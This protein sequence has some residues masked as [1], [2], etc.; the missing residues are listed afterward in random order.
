MPAIPPDFVHT[1]ETE[2]RR[3]VG[4]CAVVTGEPRVAEDLAQETLLEAW[5]HVDRLIEP[6]G[7]SPWLSAIARNICLRWMRRQGRDMAHLAA[8]LDDAVTDRS[9]VEPDLELELEH[10]ELAQLLDRALGLLP[11]E[12]RAALVAHYVDDLPQAQI[13]LDLG[14]T[15]GAVAMRLHRG[16]LALRRVLATDLRGDAEAFGLVHDDDGGADT[17]LWCPI[18]GLRRLRGRLNRATGEFILRCPSCNNPGDLALSRAEMPLL[19]RSGQSPTPAQGRFVRCSRCERLMM[20]TLAPSPWPF[21]P[22]VRYALDTEC[23]DCG[24]HNRMWLSALAFGLPEG[25]AFWRSHPRM[26]VLPEQDV[27]WHGQPAVRIGFASV[28]SSAS[29]EMLVRRDTANH[30]GWVQTTPG[31][32]R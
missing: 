23:P 15:E 32:H 21:A 2:R 28:T 7:I 27:E 26:R 3:L 20:P 14:L 8:Y 16:K 25:R 12:T 22:Q 4:L 24:T 18:C 11:F 5:R 13:A 1:L 30:G 6:S 9:L 19:H 17:Q 10:A 31:A 29:L